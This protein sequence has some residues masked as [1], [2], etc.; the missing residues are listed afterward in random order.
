VTRRGNLLIASASD[1]G[2]VQVWDP[3]AKFAVHEIKQTT[4]ITSVAISQDTAKIY[5]AGVDPSIKVW[6]FRKETEIQGQL[7]GHTE[8]VTHMSLSYDGSML[9]TNSMDA[10][11]R[12]W[13][14]LPVPITKNKERFI[15]GFQGHSVIFLMIDIYL[16]SENFD[17]VAWI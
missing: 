15:K 3:R 7:N 10:T 6:D 11:L 14:V 12:I 8:I 4:P 5:F 9:M 1:D 2:T 17:F 16:C 13:D